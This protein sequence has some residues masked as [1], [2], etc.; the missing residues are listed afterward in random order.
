M[1][2]SLRYRGVPAAEIRRRVAEAA[3]MLDIGHLLDRRPRELSGGQRQRVAM[4]RAIV[5]DPKLFLFDE[6][7]SNLDAKLRVQMRT[8]LKRL[9]D[10]LRRDH[11]LRHPRPGRGD[12]PGRPHRRAA[13]RRVQQVGTPEEVYDRP[14]T[15]FVAGFMGAPAMNL[16]PCRHEHGRAVLP[17]GGALPL[18]GRTGLQDEIW[19]GIRPESLCL[20]ARRR[21]RRRPPS[22]AAPPRS[23]SRSAPR[24]S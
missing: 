2:F 17:N 9:R 15:A 3:G 24:P 4:G 18:P 13:R 14:A 8:E 16:L 7:L 21:A 19:L 10:R 20:P 5:R 1:G 12:D 11:A 23:S 6:P 22:S